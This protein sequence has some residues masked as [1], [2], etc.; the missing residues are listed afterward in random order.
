MKIRSWRWVVSV[1]AVISM[2]GA[3]AALA[4]QAP[5]PQAESDPETASGQ[6]TPLAV[7]TFDGKVETV[8]IPSRPRGGS[9]TA[10]P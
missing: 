7:G 3:T 1:V 6:V 4:Q 5:Q 2:L 10:W 9:R 8:A